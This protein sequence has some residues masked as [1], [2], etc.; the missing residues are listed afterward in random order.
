MFLVILC[1]KLIW[2]LLNIL[3]RTVRW[4]AVMNCAASVGVGLSLWLNCT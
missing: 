3:Y 1:Y 4:S 2:R